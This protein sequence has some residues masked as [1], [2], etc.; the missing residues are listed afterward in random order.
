MALRVVASAN[1]PS[2][3]ISTSYLAMPG[4]EPQLRSGGSETTPPA[5]GEPSVTCVCLR[6]E[7]LSTS[8]SAGTQSGSSSV[9]PVPQMTRQ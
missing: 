8:S 5:A 9:L 4:T 3:L 2:W 7:A 6:K 1:L